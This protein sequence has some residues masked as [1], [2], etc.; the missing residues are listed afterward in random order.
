MTL[1][2]LTK[3]ELSLKNK[4]TLKYD[5]MTAEKDYFLAVISKLIYNSDLSQ[6]VIFKGGTAFPRMLE[7]AIERQTLM[8]TLIQ[9]CKR[10][11]Q[12]TL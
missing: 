6:K 10:I 7:E 9:E 2:L 3:Q 5:L 4:R 12:K 11:A 1:A 8:H